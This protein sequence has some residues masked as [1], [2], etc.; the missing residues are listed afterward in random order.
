[1]QAGY[2]IWDQNGIYFI[3]FAVVDWV[4]V[5]TRAAYANLVVESLQYCQKEKG[6]IIYAWC[7]MSNHLPLIV[8]AAEGFA[9]SA[10][11][12]DFKKFTSADILKATEQNPQESRRNWML[13]LFRAAGEKNSRNT[14]Y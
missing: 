9:L 2:Q 13:W 1:M 11:V 5:F 8:S 10:N 12:R 3:T 14:K 7:L 4:D 6:L